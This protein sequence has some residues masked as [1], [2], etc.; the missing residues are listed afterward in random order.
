MAVLSDS[1]QS[2]GFQTRGIFASQLKKNIL[3]R[4]GPQWLNDKSKWPSWNTAGITTVLLETEEEKEEE[5]DDN[6]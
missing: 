3:W 5:D 1:R 6:D 2:G 4:E